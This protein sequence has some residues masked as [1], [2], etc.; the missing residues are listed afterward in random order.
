MARRAGWGL[1]DQVVSSGT[2]FAVNVVVLR[3][4]GVEAFGSFSL[5]F[6][7]Y[8]VAIS[9]TR[10]YPMEPLAIRYPL[11]SEHD[12]RAAASAA[13]GTAVISGVGFSVAALAIGAA[14][15]GLLGGALV[16]LGLTFTGLVLQDAIRMAFFS[17]GRAYQAFLNDLVWAAALIPTLGLAMTVDGDVFLIT[18][19]WGIASSLAALFGL[20]QARLLPRPRRAKAW[21]HEH[22]DIGPRFLAE[23]ALRT[24]LLQIA[25]VGIA[26]IAGIAA[27]GYIRGAQ[28][29]MAPIQIVFLGLIPVLVPEGVRTLERGV[30][31]LGR[32]AVLVS[33]AEVV[34]AIAWSIVVVVGFAVIGPLVLGGDWSSFREY[35]PAA[36]GIQVATVV[37]AGPQMTL[38]ALGDARRSLRATIVGSIAGVVLPVAFAVGGPVAAA[39][40][41]AVAAAIGAA[42][43]WILARLGM[44]AR[45]GGPP[46]GDF[47]PTHTTP[48]WP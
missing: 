39:W 19:A 1:A 12:W 34:V 28:L 17:R 27:I 38:R 31:A 18:A 45:R 21:W 6:F 26:L 8:L 36:F 30:R 37:T 7:L 20:W 2:N 10:A 23:A 22:R 44:R 4:L 48:S 46:S 5:G 33:A 32:L 40:G 13:L 47:E 15:G 29:L 14:I 42:A 11:R 24:A 35:L 41:L 16:G 43:W 9:V 25:F 3:V